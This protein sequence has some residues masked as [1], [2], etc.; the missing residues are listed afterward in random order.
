MFNSCQSL[1]LD[2]AKA[3]H[4]MLI[5]G[6]AG[7]GKSFVVNEIVKQLTSE[8]NRVQLTCSTGIACAVYQNGKASTLHRFTGIEDNRHSP[9]DIHNLFSSNRKY[10]EVIARIKTTDVLIIDEIS[11]LS[12]RTFL[13]VNEIIIWWITTY[14]LRGFFTVTSC[15]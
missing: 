2:M 10:D 9:N 12:Q 8:G 14:S 3:G 15:R 5:Q 1:A 13:S 6:S 7:T 4:S 11:M